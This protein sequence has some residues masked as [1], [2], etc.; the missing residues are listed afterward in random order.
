MISAL[1]MTADKTNGL[2]SLQ[3]HDVERLQDGKSSR[4]HGWNNREVLGHVIGDGKR[5][6]SSASRQELFTDLDHLDELRR[7]PKFHRDRQQRQRSPGIGMGLSKAKAIV[8]AHGG[9]IGV[10]SQLGHGSLFHFTLP[11][12]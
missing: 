1:K 6:K 4:Q 2:R 7:V 3:P 9:S 12:H 5:R 11:I 8:E 10:T